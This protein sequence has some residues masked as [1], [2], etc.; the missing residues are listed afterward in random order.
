MPY[1]L[2]YNLEWSKFGVNMVVDYFWRKNFLCRMGEGVIW[3]WYRVL[4]EN[5]SKLTN[6]G[7]G[8]ARWDSYCDV[9]ECLEAFLTFPTASL[10][11]QGEEHSEKKDGKPRHNKKWNKATKGDVPGVSDRRK[12]CFM[13]RVWTDTSQWEVDKAQTGQALPRL[14][15]GGSVF[16]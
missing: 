10:D 5:F 14:S 12:N 9:M 1:F 16:T 15:V 4:W 11:G 13:P 3:K 7:W 2:G 6:L 8:S